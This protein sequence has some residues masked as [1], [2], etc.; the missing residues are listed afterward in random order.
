MSTVKF[1]VTKAVTKKQ[2]S[3]KTVNSHYSG[4]CRHQTVLKTKKSVK[5]EQ[6]GD[7]NARR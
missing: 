4:Q 3:L 6:D 7:Q 1:F 2:Y 5:N